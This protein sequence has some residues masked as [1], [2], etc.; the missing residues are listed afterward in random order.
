MLEILNL[1]LD[2]VKRVYISNAKHYSTLLAILPS[3]P[4]LQ[5]AIVS[6]ENSLPLPKIVEQ[7]KSKLIEVYFSAIANEFENSKSIAYAICKLDSLQEKRKVEDK[8]KLK[9][10]AKDFASKILKQEFS[11][12][13]IQLGLL[14]YIKSLCKA[15]KQ[16]VSKLIAVQLY[17]LAE[18]SNKSGKLYISSNKI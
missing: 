1:L 8:I 15:V 2:F 11:L 13:N 3:S 16:L 6:N 14:G 17:Y 5:L 7:P 10:L 18:R 4:N 12:A 9:K